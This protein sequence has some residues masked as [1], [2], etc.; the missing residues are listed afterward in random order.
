MVLEE[1]QFEGM[2]KSGGEHGKVKG[3]IRL[4]VT[5]T[6]FRLAYLKIMYQLTWQSDLKKAQAWLDLEAPFI[7]LGICLSILGSVILSWLLFQIGF[8]Y[9]LSMMAPGNSG[10]I[11]PPL[12]TLVERALFLSSTRKV[13]GLTLIE[14]TRVKKPFLTLSLW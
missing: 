13:P 7:S 9:V 10:P 14:P 5:E 4:Q 6:Q 12:V 2:T 11:S 8:P 3:E 1:E